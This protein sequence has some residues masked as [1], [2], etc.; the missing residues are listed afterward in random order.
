MVCYRVFIKEDAMFKKKFKTLSFTHQT[1][2]MS[3]FKEYL[4]AR[5]NAIGAFDIIHEQWGHAHCI[6]ADE[7]WEEPFYNSRILRK[8][9]SEDEAV[10]CLRNW[11]EDQI[12]K[13]LSSLTSS[14]R[15]AATKDQEDIT[16]ALKENNFNIEEQT[17]RLKE[18]M[19]AEKAL[20]QSEN[21]KIEKLRSRP[22]FRH[23]SK[24]KTP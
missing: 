2:D 3:I 24:R 4:M 8:N 16:A 23:W 5:G 22:F 12:E 15:K 19:A 13:R 11:E 14:F 9:L 10:E 7:E 6:S 18:N 17:A 20:I 21:A 1:S